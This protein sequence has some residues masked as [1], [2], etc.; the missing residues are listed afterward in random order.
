MTKNKQEA[1]TLSG[2]GVKDMCWRI[3]G[4]KW[5]KRAVSLKHRYGYPI[6]KPNTPARLLQ[7]YRRGNPNV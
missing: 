5:S 4:K 2:N 6:F 7:L 3:W 1:E